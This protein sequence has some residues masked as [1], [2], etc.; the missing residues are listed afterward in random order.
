[1]GFVRQT[2]PYF[3]CNHSTGSCWE[4]TAL[5]G[6]EAEPL[7]LCPSVI[8]GR[9]SYWLQPSSGSLIIGCLLTC[10]T[11]GIK[12]QV[13]NPEVHVASWMVVESSKLPSNSKLLKHT[14]AEQAV[15]CDLLKVSTT[16]LVASKCSWLFFFFFSV[17][18]IKPRAFA[19]S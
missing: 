15:V 5:I 12:D 2:G 19:L 4:Q 16:Q 18:G 11:W 6:A 14:T 1:M 3:W 7:I 9:C 10:R 13:G 8:S 17:S